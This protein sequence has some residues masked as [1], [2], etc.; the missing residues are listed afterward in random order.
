MKHRPRQL[1]MAKMT[2]T[3]RHTLT[4]SLTLE[5][6]VNGAQTGIHQAANLWLVGR[7]VHNL[8][9]FDLCDRICF[10]LLWRKNTKLNFLHLAD[11]SRG[12]CELVAEHYENR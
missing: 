3:L 1:D 11:W 2:R 10:D 12:I 8:R 6:P 7:L 9:M 4:T 5:V